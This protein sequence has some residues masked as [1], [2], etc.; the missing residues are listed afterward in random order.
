[1][2][3]KSR[4]VNPDDIRRSESDLSNEVDVLAV[5]RQ[6]FR[7]T[8]D[9]VEGAEAGP[10]WFYACA[11]LALSFGGFYMGR[12]TGLFA[13]APAVH[14]PVGPAAMMA[15]RSAPGGAAPVSGATVYAGTCAACHQAGGAG[16]PGLFPPLA[17]SEFVTGDAARLAR[18]VLNG[19]TGP[20]TVNGATYNGQM[21]PWKQLSDAEVA[22]VLTYI[23]SSW[24]N[25]APPVAADDVAKERTASATQAGPLTAAELGP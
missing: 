24:G 7:E 6:A 13:G 20:V 21:P 23:R 4:D 11:I 15:A 17:G 8:G 1:M 16:S 18:I 9:P 5:H 25:S 12:Y 14:A 19:L 22:A 3:R 10:W 2:D